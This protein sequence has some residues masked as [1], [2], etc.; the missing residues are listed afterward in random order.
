MFRDCGFPGYFH[1]Y[2]LLSRANLSLQNVS[3]IGVPL[4]Q[5][6]E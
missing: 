5:S 3:D 6:R 2:V 1:L 4:L